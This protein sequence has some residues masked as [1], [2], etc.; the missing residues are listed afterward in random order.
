MRAADPP[1]ADGSPA[2]LVLRAAEPWSPHNHELFPEACR[3][4]AVQLLL[5]GE[6]L[7]REPLFD[8]RR[9]SA[10]SLKDCWMDFVMPQAV[11][12]FG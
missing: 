3:K 1:A 5:L 2:H 11:R 6:L 12:R 10:V 7:A 8:D 4:R 9:G